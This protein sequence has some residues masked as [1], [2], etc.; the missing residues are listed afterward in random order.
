[1]RHFVYVARCSDGTLYTG[2]STDPEKRMSRHNAGKGARYTRT[3]LPVVMEY[4]EELPSI[5]AA[6]KREREIKRM[7]KAKKLSMCKKSPF[8]AHS[9]R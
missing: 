3:R 7:P 9:F 5:S 8:G 1:L 4:L 2:Y 6:L